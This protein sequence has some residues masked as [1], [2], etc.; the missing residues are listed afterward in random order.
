MWE[1]RKTAPAHTDVSVNDS[2]PSNEQLHA[3]KCVI[4]APESLTDTQGDP[5]QRAC[6]EKT[7]DLGNAHVMKDFFRG[8]Q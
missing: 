6:G 7:A 4:M 1:L 5:P 2:L 3:F 8:D